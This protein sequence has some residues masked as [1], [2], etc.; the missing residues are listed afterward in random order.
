LKTVLEQIDLLGAEVIPVLRNELD[1]SRPADVPD[2][3]THEAR[4]AAAEVD[5]DS[6]VSDQNQTFEGT[7]R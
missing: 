7:L 2:A 1:T 4:R 3:P 6:L 5:H